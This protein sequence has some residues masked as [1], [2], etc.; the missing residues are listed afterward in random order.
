ML[1][2]D[3]MRKMW[4]QGNRDQAGVI[5]GIVDAAASVFHE[6]GLDSDLLVAH[7]MAQFSHE[8]GAGLE[9][10]ENLNYSAEGLMNTW[11]KRFNAARAKAFAHQP[12]KIA[13]EVYGGRMG[14]TAPDDGW[15]F[16]GR[17]A[18]QLTGRENYA[19]LGAKLKLDLIGSPDLVNDPAN[20]L[21]CGVADFIQCGC[22]SFAKQDDVRG[23]TFH[24]NGGFNG[25][26]ARAHWLA[27]W[28]AALGGGNDTTEW[29]QAA[30]NS[31]GALPPLVVDGTYG[32]ET[33]DAVKT[34]Q[35]ANGLVADGRFG[36]ETKAAIES[37]LA[38]GTT[39]AT[40]TVMPA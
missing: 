30:L 28:K 19:K 26:E 32:Q 15:K 35:E 4:P 27:E 7:A 21:V 22:L 40:A 20:F 9:L 5:E 25:L 29:L 2:V 14:N 3:I 33:A 12:E 11:P 13:N 17:G 38:G 34:F 16:R 8:C 36:P 31:L 6:Y 37:A 39:G 23:V 18:S 10:V 24:L 1:T